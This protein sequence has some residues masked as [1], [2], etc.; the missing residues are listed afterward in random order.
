V[1][2]EEQEIYENAPIVSEPLD[3]SLLLADPRDLELEK[4]IEALQKKIK[5]SRINKWWLPNP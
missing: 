3:D 1:K 2:S 4:R 5:T